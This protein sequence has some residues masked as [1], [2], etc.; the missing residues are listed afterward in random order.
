MISEKCHICMNG[1][2]IYENNYGK[3]LNIIQNI[4]C[5]F[6]SLSFRLAVSNQNFIHPASRRFSTFLSNIISALLTSIF[7]RY[8]FTQR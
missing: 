3:D 2:G 5:G 7:S 6:Y 8:E 1:M 4:T